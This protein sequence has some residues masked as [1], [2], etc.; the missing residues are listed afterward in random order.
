VER[1]RHPLEGRTI[2]AKVARWDPDKR[3][4]NAIGIVADLRQRGWRPLLIAR[5][6][7]E[8][9]GAEVLARAH[10]LGLRIG[11]RPLRRSGAAGLLEALGGAHGLDVLLLTTHLDEDARCLL[12]HAA[13]A[14]LANSGHEPFGLVGLE[15]M[16]ASGLACTGATGEDYAA[17]GRNALVLQTDDPRE[18]SSLFAPLRRDPAASREMRR[19]ARRTSLDYA[20]PKIVARNLVPRIL[21]DCPGAGSK[22]TD[23]A[24]CVRAVSRAPLVR[25]ESS[26]PVRAGHGSPARPAVP[27]PSRPAAPARS[28]SA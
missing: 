13:D 14:V 8:S 26:L 1:F 9:H 25:V 21:L 6:G 2:L 27:T 23:P 16:A 20:W 12:L 19:A 3:W 17:S 5:G 28:V 24:G 22:V 18:F 4:L 7:A 10:A 11:E 15:T